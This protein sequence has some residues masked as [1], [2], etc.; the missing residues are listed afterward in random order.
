[1]L[2][3]TTISPAALLQKSCHKVFPSQSLEKYTDKLNRSN[4]ET[5]LIK[6]ALKQVQD[7][8]WKKGCGYSSFSYPQ[9]MEMGGREEK[10]RTWE[11]ARVVRKQCCFT[12]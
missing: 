11:N 12:A 6:E 3:V 9:H 1:M 10:E 4:W 5:L 7:W 2:S 8:Y